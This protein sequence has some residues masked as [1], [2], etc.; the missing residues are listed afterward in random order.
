MHQPTIANDNIQEYWGRAKINKQK[1]EL[2]VKQKTR[3]CGKGVILAKAGTQ[4]APS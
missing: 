1:E 2:Q 4:T 3:H